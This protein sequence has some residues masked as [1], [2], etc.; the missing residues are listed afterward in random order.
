[1]SKFKKAYEV[2][3]FVFDKYKDD[4]SVYWSRILE[5]SVNEAGLNG[6]KTGMIS[7]EALVTKVKKAKKEL[8][9]HLD[10]LSLEHPITFKTLALHALKKTK[11]MTYEDYINLWEDN[12]VT[13]VV[14]SRQNKA[15]IKFQKNFIFGVDCWKKMYEDAGIKLIRNPDFRSDYER[16]QYGLP[17]IKRGR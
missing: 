4:S 2:Y 12:L 9:H 6:E 14:T 3:L 16:R 15:L 10:N 7:T 11:P 13:T 17:S 1:M 8:I 5:C